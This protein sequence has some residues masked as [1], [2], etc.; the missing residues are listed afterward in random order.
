MPAVEPR[1]REATSADARTFDFRAARPGPTPQLQVFSRLHDVLANHLAESLAAELGAR[2]TLEPIAVERVP[3]AAYVRS[4]PQL[5]V[6]ASIALPPLEGHVILEVDPQ[7]ALAMVE[8]VLGGRGGA[9]P[10]RRPTSIEATLITE[11]ISHAREGLRTTFDPLVA[12]NPDLQQVSFDPEFLQAAADD[13]RVV[14]L[15]YDLRITDD[16]GTTEGV[17]SIA[18]PDPMAAPVLDRLS[19]SA[20]QLPAAEVVEGPLTPHVVDV[21][22]DV[23]IRLSPS[24]IRTSDL[25]ALQVGDVLRL[26]HRVDAPA[27]GFVGD[28]HTFDAHLGRRGTRLAFQVSA[29]RRAARPASTA[30]ETTP[31]DLMADLAGQPP[32]Q[33]QQ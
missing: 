21:G 14:L 8:R 24:T 22:V 30:V 18:Y 6:L 12:V 27:H 16:T 10:L 29:V 5:T 1:T 2:V 15:A 13:D 9:P 31:S 11:L 28:E 4:M 23:A 3:Y 17:I 25:A 19:H 26:D 7:L 20:A 33:E 32:M